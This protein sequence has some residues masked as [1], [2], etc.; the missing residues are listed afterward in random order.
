MYPVILDV[1]SHYPLNM[2]IV[3]AVM[4]ELYH[5]QPEVGTRVLNTKGVVVE[6][7]ALVVEHAV[8]V[9]LMVPFAPHSAVIQFPSPSVVS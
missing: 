6:L 3:C 9:L 2:Y 8:M 5:L 4:N 1:N 7:G